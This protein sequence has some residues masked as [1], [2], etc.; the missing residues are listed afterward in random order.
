[1]FNMFII[2]DGNFDEC[3]QGECKHFF[4][5]YIYRNGWRLKK[6]VV[7]VGEKWINIRAKFMEKLLFL[8]FHKKFHFSIF[9]EP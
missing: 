5:Q 1:M 6:Y 2:I 4:I 7:C 3:C 8:M 9:E